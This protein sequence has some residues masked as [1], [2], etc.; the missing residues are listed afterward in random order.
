[1]YYL[2]AFSEHWSLI[3]SC[4]TDLDF[5]GHSPETREFLPKVLP[6]PVPV[7]LLRYLLSVTFSVTGSDHTDGRGD[8][9]SRTIQLYGCA[10]I[11]LDCRMVIQLVASDGS[12]SFSTLVDSRSGDQERGDCK[13]VSV[14]AV[15]KRKVGPPLSLCWTNKHSAMKT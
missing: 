8:M 14:G 3:G 4:H 6:H 7:S 5:S 1:M 10:F 15:P 12:R 2:V 11:L 13:F 9:T